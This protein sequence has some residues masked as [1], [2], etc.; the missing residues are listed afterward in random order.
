MITKVNVR[1]FVANQ[2]GVRVEG[3]FVTAQ[4]D[5][6]DIDAL[7]G[8]ILPEEIL[9][10]TD[11][12]GACVLSLWPNVLG[13][14]NSKYVF[15]IEDPVNGTLLSVTAAIPNQDC[16]LHTIAYPE[17]SG[18]PIV[19]PA[20]VSGTTGGSGVMKRVAVRVYA[21]DQNGNPVQQAA[22]TAQL[23]RVE[24]DPT[25]GYVLPEEVEGVTNSEGICILMLWPNALGATESRY[26]FTITNPDTDGLMS[27][28]AT[29]PDVDCDLHLIADVPAYAGKTDGQLIVESLVARAMEISG[30]VAADRVIVEAAV[31]QAIESAMAAHESAENAAVSEQT[32]QEAIEAFPTLTVDGGTF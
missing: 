19:I 5:R 25:V 4:L 11:S 30:Q 10:T 12:V 14:Q 7:G 29:V 22:V 23:N 24:I 9:G 27:V 28:T 6:T 17:P 26:V 20:V 1:V 32:A 2:A 21:A 8:Y 13:S 18:N 31:L 15:T 16:D 3:A